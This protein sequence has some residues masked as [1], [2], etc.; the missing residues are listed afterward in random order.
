MYFLF[1]IFN[2]MLTLIFIFINHPLSMGLILLLQ[3]ILISIMS[4]LFSYSYWFSYILFLIMLGGM[5]V[6]FMYMT[7]LASNEMFNLSMNLMMMMMIYLLSMFFLYIFIDQM[8]INSLL[9]NSN[10][11]EMYSFMYKNENLMSL[12]SI[13]NM[14]NNMITIML[15]NY[16]FLTL[17]MV[18]KITENKFGPLRQKFYE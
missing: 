13:Y 8:I 1:L 6:L 4:S 2:L 11:M 9:K 17:I 16:L 3:T 5:L 12:N 18:V 10:M 15:M 14:P 7:S